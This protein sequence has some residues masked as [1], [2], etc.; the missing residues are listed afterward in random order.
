M[1]NNPLKYTDPTGHFTEEELLQYNVFYGPNQMAG[2]RD[3]PYLYWW[4][5]LLRAA[6][7]GDKVTFRFIQPMGVHQTSGEFREQS[8]NVSSE[9]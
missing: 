8:G 5:Y 3:D 1:R 4:Y 7:F 9:L 6:E 2:V